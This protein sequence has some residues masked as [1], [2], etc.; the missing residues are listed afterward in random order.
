MPLHVLERALAHALTRLSAARTAG[1]VPDADAGPSAAEGIG[2]VPPQAAVRVWR[3]KVAALA[4]IVGILLLPSLPGAPS[5][6]VPCAAT[7]TLPYLDRVIHALADLGGT[8]LPLFSS[9]IVI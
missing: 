7:L 1:A 6:S 4:H 2:A 8:S 9:G 3:H 5:A